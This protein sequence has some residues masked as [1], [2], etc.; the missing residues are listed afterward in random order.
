MDPPSRR[1]GSALVAYLFFVVM[2]VTVLPTP[3]Y[4]IYARIGNP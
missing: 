1:L 4:A 2:V 3:L